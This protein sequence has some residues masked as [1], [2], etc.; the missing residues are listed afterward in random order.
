MSDP[1]GLIRSHDLFPQFTTSGRSIFYLLVCSFPRSRPN[2]GNGPRISKN[3]ATF[4]K[5]SSDENSS[6]LCPLSRTAK[7]ILVLQSPV[8][9]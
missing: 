5:G 2:I 9:S 4:T 7:S 3:I 8:L 1:D 6:V